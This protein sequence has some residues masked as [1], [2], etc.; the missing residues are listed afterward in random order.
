MTKTVYDTQLHEEA[1]L[2]HS[3]QRTIYWSKSN[4][5]HLKQRITYFQNVTGIPE[6]H[7]SSNQKPKG[8]IEVEMYNNNNNNNTYFVWVGYRLKLVQ[9]SPLC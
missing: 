9:P 7:F 8:G 6:G 3:R 2:Q 4:G 5:T 1:S